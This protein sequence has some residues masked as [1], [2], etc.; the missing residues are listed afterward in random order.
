M[1]ADLAV[2]DNHFLVGVLNLCSGLGSCDGDFLCLGSS[3]L[4]L[5]LDLDFLVVGIKLLLSNELDL[6]LCLLNSLLEDDTVLVNFRL[7]NCCGYFMLSLSE[8]G[9]DLLEILGGLVVIL[10]DVLICLPH[11]VLVDGNLSPRFSYL[12]YFFRSAHGALSRCNLNRGN[13][14]LGDGFSF[15]SGSNCCRFSGSLYNFT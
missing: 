12:P 10:L 4:S 14:L 5:V 11:R 1:L 9:G 8:G 6:S 2:L 13:T 3:N 15:S 7:C